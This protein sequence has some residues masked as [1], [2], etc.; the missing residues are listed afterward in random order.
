MCTV[1]YCTVLYCTVLYCT[2]LYCTV[3]P[4]HQLVVDPVPRVCVPRLGLQAVPLAPAP[5][6]RARR[7]RTRRRVA[8]LQRPQLKYFLPASNIFSP[9]IKDIV[10]CAVTLRLAHTEAAQ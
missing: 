9:I 7:T 6:R 1:L 3:S 8:P 5:Q 2:V 4:E 10:T